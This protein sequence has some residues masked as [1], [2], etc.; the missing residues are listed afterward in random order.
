MATPIPSPV[1]RVIPITADSGIPSSTA[2]SRIAL[3]DPS[4]CS[5][6]WL[7][8]IP[9]PRRSISVSPTQN[10]SAPSAN[11]RATASAPPSAY[12]SS[13]SSKVS[14]LT[15]VP[16]PNARTS[17][18]ALAGR[19]IQVPIAAPIRSEEAATSPQPAASSIG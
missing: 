4:D 1:I 8:R 11:P 13:V 18:I 6:A 9:P 17:P 16:A 2:P 5:P 7:I 10:A 19:S 3:G 14:A 12:A 15:R